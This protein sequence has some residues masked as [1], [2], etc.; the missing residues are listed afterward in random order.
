MFV[1]HSR[2]RM[3]KQRCYLRIGNAVGK[4]I[5]SEGVPQRLNTLLIHRRRCGFAI[6][7]I[8]FMT[9]RVTL[10]GGFGV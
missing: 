2:S 1:E 10:Y 4:G 3:P 7:I 6:G 5:G 9:G 8:P